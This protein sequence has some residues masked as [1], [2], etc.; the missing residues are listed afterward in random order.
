MIVS[1]MLRAGRLL[2]V[3]AAVAVVSFVPA[4][5]ALAHASL[6]GAQ[7]VADSVLES[8]PNQV[9]LT[10]D[11]PVSATLG[12]IRVFGPGGDRVDAGKTEVTDGRLV[13]AQVDAAGRGTYTV[14]WSVLSDDGHAI[15]GSYV[16]HVGEAGGG[17][18]V[19]SVSG[20]GVARALGWVG[21]WIG[22]AGAALAGGAIGFAFL[23]GS[24]RLRPLVVGGGVAVAIG[25][26]LGLVAQIAV[27]ASVSPSAAFGVV[28]EAVT[29]TRFGALSA[30][31][32]GAALVLCAVAFTRW[33]CSRSFWFWPVALFGL[34]VVILPAFSGHA[35]AT[36]PVAGSILNDAVHLAASSVWIGGLVALLACVPVCDDR[37][38]LLE[39]FSAVALVAAALTVLTGAISSWLE[40]GSPSALVETAY[41]RWLIVKAV[42]VVALLVL[43]SLGR[44]QVRRGAERLARVLGL[45]RGEVVVAV[46]VFAVTAALVAIQPARSALS[47]PYSETLP[48]ADGQ[49]NLVV[50]PARTGT[51]EMHLYFLTDA[52]LPRDVDAVEVKVATGD[53]PARKIDLEIITASH[54]LAPAVELPS[55]GIWT[56]MVTSVTAG[57]RSPTV[58]V[59]VPIR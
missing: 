54:Y 5:P 28:P 33:W 10:F 15:D 6:V 43:G 44:V 24:G 47:D 37:R 22:F 56:F 55:P 25:T 16:Y 32:I 39:R 42:L 18:D 34:A 8:A 11:E 12:G 1:P 9:E 31:R 52:G 45:V 26:L 40:V 17:A 57:Q 49:I 14:A 41:G 38:S 59:E 2:L 58:D 27:L 19:A 20:P 7:P 29:G 13:T 3:V 30:A 21:R 46:G 36:S 4:V 53:I 51:N 50:D 48:E 35:S 23:F